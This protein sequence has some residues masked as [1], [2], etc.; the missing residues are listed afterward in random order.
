MT[1]YVWAL[2]LLAINGACTDR[3]ILESKAG[4]R[5]PAVTGLALQA[6]AQTVQLSWDLPSGLP[7]EIEQPVSVYI[8]VNEIINP[9]R[10][11]TVFST[12]LPDAPTSFSYEIP[13][14]SKK[15]NFTVKL[16][17]RTKMPD[18]NYH[19]GEIYSEGRTVSYSP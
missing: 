11:L 1:M 14:G 5:L 7:A 12:I 8:Q 18:V 15:Y 19:S 13:D 16:Y 10:S 17:G 9:A 2:I 6:T 4:V 3:D